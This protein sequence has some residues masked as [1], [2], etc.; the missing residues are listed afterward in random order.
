MSEIERRW[1]EQIID[2]PGAYNHAGGECVQSYG[3]TRL[4]DCEMQEYVVGWGTL[5]LINA[6]IANAD[7][8]GPLKYFIGSIFLG[9]IITIILAATREGEKSHLR[10]VDIWR[11]STARESE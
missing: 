7:G 4:E 6:A 5:A 9:P 11:G 10:Q 8:R 3:R 1:N 2:S